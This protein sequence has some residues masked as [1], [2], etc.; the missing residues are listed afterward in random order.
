MKAPLV[1]G[2]AACATAED[3]NLGGLCEKGVCACFPQWTRPDCGALHLLANEGPSGF[4]HKDSS[5]WGGS[6]VRG[7]D[8]FF[9]MYVSRITSK[10]GIRSWYPNSE[11][12]HAT[13]ATAV[14][15]Y[16]YADTVVRRFAH[17]PTAHYVDGKYLLS[18]PPAFLWSPS[19]PR[20]RPS[21]RRCS[22]TLP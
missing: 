18:Q 20:G 8:G 19:L 5:S 3:C 22:R 11:I 14:G 7:G 6:I 13:S 10:C 15:P 1:K 2:G 9:H 12:V 21:L 17:N 16:R 4:S